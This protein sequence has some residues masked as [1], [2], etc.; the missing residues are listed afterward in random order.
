MDWQV[1]TTAAKD[2][3]YKLWLQ[4]LQALCTECGIAL[5]FDEVYTGFRMA[6]GGAQEFYGVQVRRPRPRPARQP[7]CPPPRPQP[8]DPVRSSPA[9]PCSPPC[10]LVLPALQPRAWLQADMVWYGQTT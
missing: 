4:Q 7:H 1:R 2:D 3:A 9:T 6:V 5:V 10:N 8:C